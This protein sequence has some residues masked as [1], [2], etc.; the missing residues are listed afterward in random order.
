MSEGRVYWCATQNGPPD[1]KNAD[2]KAALLSL[3]ENGTRRFRRCSKRPIP[4]RFSATT[5]TIGRHSAGGGAGA[6]HCSA[7]RRTR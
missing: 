7:M 6:R 1:G 3:F 5:S 4:R 2:E